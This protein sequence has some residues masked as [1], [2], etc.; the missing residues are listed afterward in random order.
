[1]FFQ[2]H[3]IDI[4][5]VSYVKISNGTANPGFRYGNF[6][7]GILI[8]QLNVIK[9]ETLRERLLLPWK[10]PFLRQAL[11]REKLSQENSGNYLQS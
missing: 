1:M 10:P 8:V 9:E 3:N 4:V 11:L 7:Y 5:F 2:R 6:K